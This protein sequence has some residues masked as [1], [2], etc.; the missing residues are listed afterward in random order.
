MT[1]S[2]PNTP[3]HWWLP[4]IA[5]HPEAGIVYSDEDKLDGAGIR[6][7]PYFKPDFDP[8]LLIGQNYLSHLCLFRRD[9]VTEAGG[10]R[11]G[12]EG[13]QDWDLTLRVSELVAPEQVV[14]IPHVLYHWRAHAGSTA[15]GLSA[16]P[17]AVDAGRRAVV[18]HLGQDGPFRPGHTGA[19]RKLGVQPRDLGRSRAR[20]AREHH[21]P[22]Q[23]RRS[24][25]CNGAS[26][27]CCAMTT[28]PQ[29]RGRRRGQCESD[30]ADLANISGHTRIV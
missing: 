14:H 28:Y 12:Y 19:D 3:W 17:Y 24:R 5:E 30:P 27:A 26:T 8:L 21:H 9:L 11:E 20:A 22:H 15:S 6:H 18:D 1:T 2:W 25:S 4:R 16:K 10:Y 29:L 23:G 7:G 13:S